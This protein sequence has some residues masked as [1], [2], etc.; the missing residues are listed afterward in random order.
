MG[1]KVFFHPQ[2]RIVHYGGASVRFMPAR[3]AVEYRR[4]QLHVYD[5]HLPKWQARALRTYLSL[6]FHWK[7]LR[8]RDK[9]DKQAAAQ[10]LELLKKK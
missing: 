2:A 6:K 8:S 9:E 1:H 10:I 7:L 3:T 5:K 4:S